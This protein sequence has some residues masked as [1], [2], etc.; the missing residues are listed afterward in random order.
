METKTVVNGKEYKYYNQ[1]NNWIK[2]LKEAF[3][4]QK[5]YAGYPSLPDNSELGLHIYDDANPEE[6]RLIFYTLMTQFQESLR[7][8]KVDKDW[9]WTE[10]GRQKHKEFIEKWEVL[11]PYMKKDWDKFW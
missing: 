1:F 4:E 10:E 9:L 3:I 11:L 6:R 2:S 5:D 7:H 8:W